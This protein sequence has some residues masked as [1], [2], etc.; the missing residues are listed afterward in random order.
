MSNEQSVESAISEDR[1][2][3][4]GRALANEE[5]LDNEQALDQIQLTDC[6]NQKQY[7]EKCQI[8]ILLRNCDSY[9]QKNKL[10][11]AI[12]YL[13]EA[14]RKAHRLQSEDSIYSAIAEKYA[15]IAFFYLNEGSNDDAL[16]IYEKAYKIFSLLTDDTKFAIAY[17]LMTDL[18]IMLGKYDEAASIQEKFLHIDESKFKNQPTIIKPCINLGNFYASK[19]RYD[20]AILFYDK[21]LAISET[22]DKN[23]L[24]H[25]EIVNLYDKI[26]NYYDEQNRYDDAE[27]VRQKSDS[28]RLDLQHVDVVH[29]RSTNVINQSQGIVLLD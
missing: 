26:V 16:S 2:L 14:Q 29:Q 15:D 1:R 5:T 6:N 20:N 23:P 11:L 10:P 21:A 13:D 24:S 3:S 9:I 28:I 12:K 4:Y 27:A 25:T 19:G 8:K 18:Y 17:F 7:E 22:F